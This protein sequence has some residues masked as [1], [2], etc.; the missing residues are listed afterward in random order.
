MSD[1]IVN[2][3]GIPKHELL[4]ALY[5]NTFQ[6]GMGFMHSR[7]AYDMTPDQAKDEIKAATREFRGKTEIYFDYLHGRVMKVNIGEDEMTTWG[8]NR[9]V[10]YGA[11]EK[12]VAELRKT[13]PLN[14]E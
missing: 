9:D 7:G 10:G 4:A 8:Y 2:I 5:N 14:K 12:V 1:H 3:A 11:A 13:Y 6:Q